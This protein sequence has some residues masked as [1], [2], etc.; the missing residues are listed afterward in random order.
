VFRS[1]TDRWTAQIQA[2][3]P[4][5]ALTTLAGQDP[6]AV[7]G[8]AR[9]AYGQLLAKAATESLPIHAIRGRIV[10]RSLTYT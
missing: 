7:P 6:A 8:A 2:D 3:K 10:R 5:S 1:G 4:D 9:E